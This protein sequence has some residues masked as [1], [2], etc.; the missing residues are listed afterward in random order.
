MFID[1]ENIKYPTAK[2]RQ[3]GKSI[4]VS[5]LQGNEGAYDRAIH[6]QDNMGTGEGSFEGMR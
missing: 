3:M 4:S 6:G 2:A 5:S 1:F